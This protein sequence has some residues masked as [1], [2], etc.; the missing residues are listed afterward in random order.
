MKYFALVALLIVPFTV[1][2]HGG[3]GVVLSKVT[4]QGYLVDV[5]Y[6]NEAFTVGEPGTFTFGLYTDDSRTKK[7]EFSDIWVRV[8]K[9]G[10]DG[11]EVTLFAGSVTHLPLAPITLLYGFT[12]AGTYI[13]DARYNK[14][15]ENVLSQQLTEAE[16]TF[17]V[18]GEE[19]PASPGVSKEF[20]LGLFVGLLSAFILL[21]IRA[22]IQKST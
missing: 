9:K 6:S 1:L 18:K 14:P 13:L 10:A 5:D 12:E 7:V 11:K 20:F 3:E 2:A 21:T 17:D 15:T 19:T 22:K 4:D 16:F 8:V